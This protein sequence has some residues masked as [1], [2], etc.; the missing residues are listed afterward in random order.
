MK[1][2]T[3][4]FLFC[5]FS[6]FAQ[7]TLNAKFDSIDGKF[8]QIRTI[9]TAKDHYSVMFP[10]EEMEAKF[11]ANYRTNNLT[12][13]LGETT[14]HTCY[15]VHSVIK[16]QPQDEATIFNGVGLIMMI[17]LIIIA[18]RLVWMFFWLLL[19]A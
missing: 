3:I 9:Y 2:L 7:L 15:S 6:T 17:F 19:F 1:Y 18:I 14:N 16:S 5:S 13:Q 10:T 4:I 8:Q 12:L 11:I